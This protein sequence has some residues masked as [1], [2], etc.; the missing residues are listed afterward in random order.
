MTRKEQLISAIKKA[1]TDLINFRHILLTNSKDDVSPAP[2]HSTWSELL[3]NGTGHTAVQ[4]FRESAKTQYINRA[5]LLY[6]LMFPDVSRDYIIIIKKNQTLARNI[7]REIEIE[8]TTNPVI[9]ANRK[10]TLEESGDV[11]SV[12]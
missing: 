6:S 2:F 7:L 5:F 12:D 1:K 8:A 4:G 10:K 9:E 11:Y 3:L